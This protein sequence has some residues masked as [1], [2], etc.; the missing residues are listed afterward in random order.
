MSQDYIDIL[1][2]R[3]KK[4]KVGKPILVT[5]IHRSGT[6]WVG[7]MIS[8]SNSVQ[9][10]HEPFNIHYK[11]KESPIEH[12]FEY[13]SLSTS[14][15]TEQEVLNYL[16]SMY[17][18]SLKSIFKNLIKGDVN[19]LFTSDDPK[20]NLFGRPLLKDPIAIM[21][22]PWLYNK[23]DCDVIVCIRHP[24]AFVASIKEKDWDFDF[25]QLLE[26][27][28]LMKEKLY[29]FQEKIREFS[30]TPPGIVSQGILLWNIIYSRVIEYRK[31]FKG[32]WIF[33]KHE[34]ISRRPV[35]EFKLM[36]NKLDIPFGLEIKNEIIESTEASNLEP[37]KRNS[38]RNIFR[39]KSMLSSK[40]I[41]KIKKETFKV[42][43]H[44]YAESDW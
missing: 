31:E 15:Q 19:K 2:K 1:I 35:E 9:Y 39:W 33:I 4:I 17:R 43:S 12:W 42:W 8:E 25:N 22:A 21:S 28:K 32:K 11:G 6:T 13:Y 26:Q 5:G 27:E 34:D 24:A 18:P 10:I 41:E 20:G 44:Y 36:F 23:L 37:L 38:R 29:P 7:R 14:A 3:F 40:D 30:E 16:Q